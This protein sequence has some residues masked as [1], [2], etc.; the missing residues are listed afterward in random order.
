MCG[1]VGVVSPLPANQLLYDSLLLLQH[2]GQDSAGIATADGSRFHMIVVK[3]TP[4]AGV[5]A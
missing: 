2:R 3:E 4:R 1:I 5:V